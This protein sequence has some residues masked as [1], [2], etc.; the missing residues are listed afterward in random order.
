M[1]DNNNININSSK[2]SE[3]DFNIHVQGIET[4]NPN[5]DTKVRFVICNTELNMDLAF[6]CIPA[7]QADSTLWKVKFPQFDKLLKQSSYQFH[8]EVV[9]DG[10]YF[11]PAEGTL[12][13]V[14]SPKIDINKTSKVKESVVEI[15]QESTPVQEQVIESPPT[16]KDTRSVVQ[17]TEVVNEKPVDDIV[18]EIVSEKTS[19]DKAVQDILSSLVHEQVAQSSGTASSSTVPTNKLLVPEFKPEDTT[20]NIPNKESDELEDDPSKTLGKVMPTVKET[21]V[22]VIPKAQ[23]E[24]ATEFN[25]ESIAKNLVEKHIRVSIPTTKGSLFNRGKDGKTI[26]KGFESEEVKAAQKQ[27]ADKVKNL[28]KS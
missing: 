20:K 12:I 5:T 28:L 1:A 6:P 9:V 26:V 10:Y 7:D 27:K 18:K 15:K 13:F 3:F 8:V 11:E 4:D 2:P 24:P 16:E 23:T 19:K 17:E 25:P 22:P 21:V 14:G